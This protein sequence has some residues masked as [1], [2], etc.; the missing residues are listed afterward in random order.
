MKHVVSPSMVA[1]LWVHQTQSNARNSTGS[2]YF[3]GKSIYSYGSHFQIAVHREFKGKP[4]VA[5]TMQTY[6]SSTAK[7]VATTQQACIHRTVFPNL[8]KTHT[9]MLAYWHNQQLEALLKASRARANSTWWLA[10]AGNIVDQANAFIDFFELDKPHFKL[11]VDPA[12]LAKIKA[13]AAAES[14]RQREK[15]KSV[16]A[17]Y[18]KQRDETVALWIAGKLRVKAFT[19]RYN[20]KVYM[21][22]SGDIVQ[23]SKGAEFPVAHAKRLFKVIAKCM[24][25]GVPYVRNGHTERVGAFAVD[26]IKPD[27]TVHAGCHKIEWDEV[28]RIAKLIGAL[29]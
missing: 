24:A 21:R 6:S 14:E 29:K 27:G 16:N 8:E 1:H 12:A 20:D 17:A 3:T 23:T 26:L 7:H 22:I 18:E 10:E 15:T 13:D 4:Y 5:M 9:E 19:G 2:F 28:Q 11:E 25:S